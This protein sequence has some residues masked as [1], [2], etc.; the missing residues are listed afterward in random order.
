[1]PRE[2][3]FVDRVNIK[4][5]IGNS[6]SLEL[7]R[8][9]ILENNSSTNGRKAETLREGSDPAFEVRYPI[10]FYYVLNIMSRLAN[11]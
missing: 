11:M 9:Q 2:I 1:M 6:L 7:M 5:I 4:F 3:D 10:Y 8:K